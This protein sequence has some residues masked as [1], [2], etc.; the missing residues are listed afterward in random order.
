M[1]IKVK[2]DTLRRRI[3]VHLHGA[4]T[5][6]RMPKLVDSL[7]KLPNDIEVH[8]H[9]QDLGYID[10]ACVEAISSWEKQRNE[11]SARTVVEWDEL[12]EK[13]RVRNQI[14]G[15]KEEAMVA[16]SVR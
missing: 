11:R 1:T 2:H 5:F 8:V 15:A 16:E 7:E 12:M 4:A 14:P 3:D 9:I 10:H 13:Y 6:I